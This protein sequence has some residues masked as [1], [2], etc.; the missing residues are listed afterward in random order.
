MRKSSAAGGLASRSYGCHWALEAGTAALARRGATRR[1]RSPPD[2]RIRLKEHSRA[3]S[4]RR[5]L[6]MNRSHLPPLDRLARRSCSCGNAATP[7][8]PSSSKSRT[9]T[10]G[11]CWCPERS[12]VV[13]AGSAR[14]FAEE[15]RSHL[16][17]SW[18]A[19]S[20]QLMGWVRCSRY[21]REG[22]QGWRSVTR[23]AA[24]RRVT[25][26]GSMIR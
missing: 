11:S 16:A 7:A 3:P 6:R 15:Q 23:G 18:P 13:A 4:S 25:G 1:D 26:V 19:S 2:Y 17:R 5:P 14:A 10:V 9:A 8:L 24:T 12:L 21:A 20:C 22:A